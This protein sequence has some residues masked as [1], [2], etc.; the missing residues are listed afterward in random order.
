[1]QPAPDSLSLTLAIAEIATERDKRLYFVSRLCGVRPSAV[2]CCNTLYGVVYDPF[3]PTQLY[4]RITTNDDVVVQSYLL[5]SGQVWI[6]P[7]DQKLFT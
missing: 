6:R 5:G 4:D 7:A 1:M 3:V 2:R